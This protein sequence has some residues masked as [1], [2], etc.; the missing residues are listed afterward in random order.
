MT[1]QVGGADLSADVNCGEQRVEHAVQS[2]LIVHELASCT[3]RR[4]RGIE[5]AIPIAI[6]CIN[7]LL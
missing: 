1:V 6:V 5:D 3:L 7:E 4:L 2:D